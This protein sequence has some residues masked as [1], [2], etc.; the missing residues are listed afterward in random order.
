MSDLLPMDQGEFILFQADDGRT[1]IQCRFENESIWLTQATLAELFRTTT[2]NITLHLKAIYGQG[3]LLEEATCKD[4]LQVRTEGSR[5]VKRKLKYYNLDAILAVGYRVQ[6]QMGTQFRQWATAQLKEFLVKGFVL[7]DERLKNPPGPGIPDH[8]D[9]MLERI[10]DIRASERRMY[11]RLRDILALA[12]DYRQQ[13]E[14]AA[15]VFFQTVQNKLHFAVT[16]KTAPELI[17]ERATHALP[18]MGL[19]TWKGGVVRKADVTVAKNYLQ[20]PEIFE[21]NRIVV[22]FLDYA[23][24]QATRRKN[25]FLE[26]WKNKLDAFLQFNERNVLPGLGSVTREMADRKAHQEYE[27][28]EQCRRDAIEA[29]AEANLAQDLESAVKKLPRSK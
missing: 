2:Q 20:E 13:P 29:E 17:L 14:E 27:Q 16:G 19:T 8:F 9:E 15:K 26:D 25:V 23:E 24:D 6:S 7:D 10:R 11:L 21:L 28:Y 22:M 12:A 3:E 5:Q 18:N 4:Y 1:R